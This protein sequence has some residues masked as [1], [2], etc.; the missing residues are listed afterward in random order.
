M[1][2]AE[3][4]E[5][6]AKAEAQKFPCPN[7]QYQAWS[8]EDLRSHQL[9]SHGQGKQGPVQEMP[10]AP[11]RKSREER[12]PPGFFS[13]EPQPD[14]WVSPTVGRELYI[15]G[16]LSERGENVNVMVVGPAGAGKTSLGWEFAS[17]QKRPCFEVPC[18]MFMEPGEG[19]G[20]GRLSREQ[21]TYYEQA[22]YGG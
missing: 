3:R 17:A 19:W 12:P 7:C 11:P 18:G 10:Q 5:T 9:F 4:G 1:R 13:P 14:F 16:K 6:M 2:Q 15:I 20:E 22:Q 21:G 8:Q